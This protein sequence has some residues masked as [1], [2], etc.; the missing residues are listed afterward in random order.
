MHFVA[1]SDTHNRQDR[2][3]EW[4][5]PDGDTLIHAGDLTMGGTEEEILRA[6]KWLQSLPH[7]RKIVVAGNHDFLFEEDGARSMEI[8]VDHGLEVLED[9]GILVEGILVW[10]T[11]Y[12]PWFHQWAFNVADE[13]ER[14]KHYDLIPMDTRILVTHTPPYGILDMTPHGGAVGCKEMLHAVLRVKPEYH[15]FGHI[16]HSYGMA[17]VNGT[18]FMNASSC[19]ERYQLRNPA[20]EFDI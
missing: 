4:K 19:N 10:G 8:A 11:P 2:C 14:K 12:Q 16:H 3:P 7:K 13:R 5:V 6:C 9:C 15:I 1:I 20:F 18:T 17:C